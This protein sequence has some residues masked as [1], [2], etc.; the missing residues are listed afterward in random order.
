MYAY[1]AADVY[2]DADVYEAAE[3]VR[4]AYARGVTVANLSAYYNV[5]PSFISR[6]VKGQRLVKPAY[7]A[8][9]QEI[10]EACKTMPRKHVAA[11]Y[12][13]SLYIVASI[14]C[15]HLCKQMGNTFLPV[16]RL[17]RRLTDQQV[18]DIRASKDTLVVMA[19]RYGVSVMLLSRIRSRYIYK[20]VK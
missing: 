20:D 16:A 1:E 4:L 5:S 7:P 14:A 2:E 17:P 6:I 12:N 10:Y 11:K 18:K 15:G 19:E 3:N 8:H 9:Y 13:I